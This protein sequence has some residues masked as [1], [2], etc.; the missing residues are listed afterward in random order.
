MT[1]EFNAWWDTDEMLAN[2]PYHEESPIWWAFEGWSAAVQHAPECK[3]QPELESQP[4]SQ[5]TQSNLSVTSSDEDVWLS[6]YCAALNKPDTLSSHAVDCA[7]YGLA[8]F[9]TRFR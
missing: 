1:P 2:N 5:P 8:A 4:E 3:S 7:D 6:V 9:R